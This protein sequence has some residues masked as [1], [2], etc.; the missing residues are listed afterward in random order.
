MWTDRFSDYLDGA[1]D[2]PDRVRIEAHLAECGD[3]R[4]VLA[5]LRHVVEGATRLG[6]LE[7][8]RDLWPEIAAAIAG[9]LREETQAGEP[10]VIEFPRTRAALRMAGEPARRPWARLGPV[11]RTAAAA[12]VLAVSVATTWWLASSRARPVGP[13]GPAGAPTVDVLQ[14]ARAGTPPPDLAAELATLEDVL[15]A[16]RDAL[17]PN[18]VLVLERNLGVI[19]RAIADSREALAVDPGNAFLTEHLERM[20][21]R[22]LVYLQDAVRVAGWS[23]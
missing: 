17:D 6:E 14:T 20:Y 9:P 22:K 19:E 8:P 23:S 1:L 5:G 7:P 4:E 11:P 15:A 12:A 2:A 10:D 13:L 21:R 18:T 16:A 3:C